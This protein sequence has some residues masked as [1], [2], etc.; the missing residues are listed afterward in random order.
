MRSDLYSHVRVEK[1]ELCWMRVLED[2]QALEHSSP[3]ELSWGL[4]NDIDS[5]ASSTESLRKEEYPL[6]V[7]KSPHR[8]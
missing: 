3:N 7:R 5:S 2:S 4:N 6:Q 1:V 8:V